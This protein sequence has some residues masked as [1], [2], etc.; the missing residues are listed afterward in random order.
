MSPC[1]CF[2]RCIL[3]LMCCYL[4]YY[5]SYLINILEILAIVFI[6]KQW[7]NINRPLIRDKWKSSLIKDIL[8][9]DIILEFLFYT[10]IFSFLPRT[11]KINKIINKIIK[12]IFYNSF[13]LTAKLNGKC[14]D[15]P[16]NPYPHTCIASPTINIPHQSGTFVT[17]DEPS[18]T[19]HIIYKS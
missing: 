17:P 3:Y 1:G 8:K 19:Y 13:R 15:S 2:P 11:F 18:L 10:T 9:W 6:Q 14:R 4:M 5:N 7:N 16:C 12:F